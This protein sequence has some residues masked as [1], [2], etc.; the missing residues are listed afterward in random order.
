M[1][2]DK[3]VKKRGVSV[4]DMIDDEPVLT[5]NLDEDSDEEEKVDFKVQCRHHQ[6]T[7]HEYKYVGVL[8]DQ[9][10]HWLDD[11]LRQFA[12]YMSL[13]FTPRNSQCCPKCVPNYLQVSWGLVVGWLRI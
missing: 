2:I 10:V 12:F 8:F 11:D 1:P 6:I 7:S 5:V 13:Y 3:P 4:E 9:C